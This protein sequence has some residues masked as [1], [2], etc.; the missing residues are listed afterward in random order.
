MKI[1]VKVPRMLYAS[2]MARL[3]SSSPVTDLLLV[4]TKNNV[5]TVTMNN[6]KK[7]NGWTVAMCNSMFETFEKLDKDEET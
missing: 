4:S 6:P 7:L 2:H 3:M 1:F 5:T